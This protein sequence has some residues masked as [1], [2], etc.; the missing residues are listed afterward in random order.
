MYGVVT[1]FKKKRSKAAKNDS[2]A[3]GI[4]IAS[5]LKRFFVNPLIT[6]Q[7]RYIRLNREVTKMENKQDVII[8]LNDKEVKLPRTFKEKLLWL[9]PSLVLCSIAIGSGEAILTPYFASLYG[10]GL[11]W[12]PVMSALCKVFIT[13]RLARYTLATGE[14]FVHGLYH[15]PG[16]KGWAIVITFI[17]WIFIAFFLA[18]GWPLGV[19]AAFYGAVSYTG[20]EFADGGNLFVK[21]V[22]LIVILLSMYLPVSRGGYKVVETI[23]KIMIAIVVVAVFICGVMLF[24]P[25]GEFF[26]NIVPW[27]VVDYKPTE[28]ANITTAIGYSGGGVMAISSYSYWVREKGYHLF[29]QQDYKATSKIFGM[30]L[31]L[32]YI[33]QPI[34]AI[35]III[36]AGQILPQVGDVPNGRE[37]ILI[38]ANMLGEP[39][40]PWAKWIWLL[41]G[42][43]ILF[44]TSVAVFDGW[45]RALADALKTLF[46]KKLASVSEMALRRAVVI[47]MGVGG[48][49]FGVFGVSTPGTFVSWGSVLEGI[50][51]YPIFG[52]LA[53]VICLKLLPKEKRGSTILTVL[54]ILGVA[55]FLYVSISYLLGTWGIIDITSEHSIAEMVSI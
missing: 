4:M 12:V 44:S 36:C 8:T 27:N 16:P 38:T 3:D 42:A 31:A 39:L 22:A 53:I 2:R 17:P 48:I 24:P 35:F 29:G 33:I 9:G 54:A 25:I 30:D 19:G 34:C 5:N 40:G 43:A 37:I 45:S 55:Y 23:C 51:F 10:I 14:T 52:T 18:V 15:L 11:L 47:F 1:V 32:A 50:I 20:V 28:I 46:N 13:E 7:N 21:I 6:K 26:T 49:I 41:G